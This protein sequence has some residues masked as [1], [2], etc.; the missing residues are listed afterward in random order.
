[1]TIARDRSTAAGVIAVVV[2]GVV[3]LGGTTLL[4]AVQDDLPS[5]IAIHWG[6]DGADGWASFS[7]VLWLNGLLTVG[8]PALLLVPAVFM[9]RSVRP[10]LAATGAGL[11]VFVGSIAYGTAWAQSR[12]P[13]VQP[14]PWIVGAGL[15]GLAVGGLL[16]WWARP[17]WAADP[18]ER[19]GPPPGA[20]IVDVP[21]T[22][23]LAWVGRI[24][25][26]LGWRVVLVAAVLLPALV[27]TLVSGWTWVSAVFLVPLVIV[28]L[29]V[30]RSRQLVVD[31]SGV[32]VRSRTA[33][34]PGAVPLE[35]VR[36][37][38]VTTV[39]ALRDFG[40]WGYRLG[41]D[42]RRGWITRSGEA[43]VVQR[44]AEPD[45]LFTVDG[46]AE[47]AAVLNTLVARSDS[48]G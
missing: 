12:A 2:A 11:A 37:A 14:A 19:R 48:R 10:A 43:L 42:G 27:V 33:L 1:M 26:P 45:L 28:L 47:A 18:M 4:L 5:R 13:D 3:V 34:G 31:H 9:H 29:V 7:S 16:Y 17:V 6:V 23:K 46:A 15:A 40:G 32:G 41:R 25:M 44:V 35:K 8:L 24:G 36:S 20:P 30:G 38:D 39:R 21:A 22:T